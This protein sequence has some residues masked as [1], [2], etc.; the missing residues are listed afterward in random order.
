LHDAIDPRVRTSTCRRRSRGVSFRY[1]LCSGQHRLCTCQNQRG[2]RAGSSQRSKVVAPSRARL[3][4]GKSIELRLYAR[5]AQ[6]APSARRLPGNWRSIASLRADRPLLAGA[7]RLGRD[8]VQCGWYTADARSLTQL[9]RP[10]L[11]G[12]E[13]RVLN[14]HGNRMTSLKGLWRSHGHAGSQR[15]LTEALPSPQL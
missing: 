15:Y 13:H 14:A 4:S 5:P 1:P 8:L 12:R 2:L 11:V 6:C 9:K 10:R 3:R 7:V